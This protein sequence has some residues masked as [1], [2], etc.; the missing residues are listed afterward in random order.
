MLLATI[1][2]VSYF[3]YLPEVWVVETIS[4]NSLR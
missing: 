2:M 1:A 3:L 4:D